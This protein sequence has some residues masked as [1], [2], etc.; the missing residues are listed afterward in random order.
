MINLHCV[1]R[2][3]HEIPEIAMLSPKSTARDEACTSKIKINRNRDSI[4]KRC[5]IIKSIKLI[6]TL[7]NYY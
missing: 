6:V 5:A 2:A 7:T 1:A 4:F 3:H